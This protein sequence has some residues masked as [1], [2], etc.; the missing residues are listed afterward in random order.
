VLATRMRMSAGDEGVAIFGDNP[1]S[2]DGVD[3]FGGTPKAGILV[4]KTPGTFNITP[5]VEGLLDSVLRVAGG[6]AG[7]KAYSTASST[8]I[9][10]GG[11]AGGTRLDTDVL[12][13]TSEYTLVVGGKGVKVTGNNRNY[14]TDAG[15]TT[16]TGL[17]STTGGG[18]GGV[19]ASSNF[20]GKAGGSG[21]GGGA[22]TGFSNY[23]SGGN[24]T[25]GEG[26]NGASATSAPRGGGGG[27][28][29][30]AGDGAT[31]GSG[32]SYF[33]FTYAVG[34]N[35][36]SDNGGGTD[37]T[38]PGSGGE[39]GRSSGANLAN[40]GNGADGIIIVSWGGFMDGKTYNPLTDD[41][42]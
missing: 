6:G 38:V 32:E 36:R 25:S 42:D 16:F 15:N 20:D 7:G 5:A 19:G 4:W 41:I 14:A 9:G 13:E 18:A 22:F 3:F 2:L 31:G 40:S 10:G 17:S 29:G 26:N 8:N 30:S 1:A 27:G 34:G 12:V 35:A 39:G 23:G 33:G 21:G 24:G 11:G 28:K 37:A